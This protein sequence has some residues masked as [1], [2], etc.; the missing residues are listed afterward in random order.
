MVVLGVVVTGVVVVSVIISVVVSVVVTVVASV[1]VA[2]VAAAVV[3]AAVVVVDAVV[4]G[5]DV[6]SAVVSSATGDS[7]LSQPVSPAKPT[8][9]IRPA[10]VAIVAHLH[11]RNG[12]FARKSWLL[13]D[14]SKVGMFGAVYDFTGVGLVIIL[15]TVLSYVSMR[16]LIL[17]D[18]NTIE[19]GKS[20]RFLENFFKFVKL[21][22]NAVR[23]LLGLC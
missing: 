14:S 9:P 17:S 20:L 19:R 21:R 22:Q 11:Q 16:K 15:I 2:V 23:L 3:V 10:Q 1:V 18:N 8:V 6:M 12:S 13:R 7:M 4:L 5:S